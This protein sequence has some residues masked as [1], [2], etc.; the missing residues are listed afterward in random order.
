M[1]N[2][3]QSD[4]EDDD[5]SDAVRF[6]NFY[7]CFNYLL[8]SLPRERRIPTRKEKRTRRRNGEETTAAIQTATRT[9]TI[10]LEQERPS[11]KDSPIAIRTPTMTPTRRRRS[12]A[13]PT[14]IRAC[15]SKTT[16]VK[17]ATQH[18]HSSGQFIETAKDKLI[19]KAKLFFARSLP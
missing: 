11:P 8:I 14:P 9:E 17:C 10:R 15:L 13:T 19:Q 4:D 18:I 2:S 1:H 6:S 7:P 3:D 16:H 5:S 12:L